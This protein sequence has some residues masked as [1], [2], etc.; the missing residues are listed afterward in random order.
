MA[1]F[2]I[3]ITKAVKDTAERA[4]DEYQYK[5]LTIRQWADKIES[6]EYQ[7]VKHGRWIHTDRFDNDGWR[8][9]RCSKCN[10]EIRCLDENSNLI[11]T[12]E[13][14]CANCGAKMDGGDDE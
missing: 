1:E 10:F 12:Q 7:P 4:L 3:D 11:I 8:I 9:Y 6:C 13:K 14:Y 5:G 2:I